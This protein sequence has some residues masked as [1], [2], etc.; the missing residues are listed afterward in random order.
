MPVSSNYVPPEERSNEPLKPNYYLVKI[1]DIEDQTKEN[2]FFKE[3][4]PES[5]KMRRQFEV[6][7]DVIDE[8][9][10]AGVMLRVWMNDSLFIGKNT[11]PTNLVNFLKA[12][13]GKVFQKADKAT[14]T[15][16]FWNS[17][18]GSEFRVS[19]G[20]EEKDSVEYTSITG[21]AAK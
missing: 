8:K 16:E 3:G 5:A 14:L 6:K 2:K 9:A 18:I 7:L 1:K 20:I 15:T 10:P 19:T 21:F 17:M 4:D 11:K 13:T 12:V